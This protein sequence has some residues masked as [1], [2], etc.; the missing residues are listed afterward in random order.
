[1]RHQGPTHSRHGLD[2]YYHL[3]RHHRSSGNRRDPYQHAA[4]LVAIHTALTT[5]ASH[6]WIGIFADSLFSVQAVRHHSTNNSATRSSLHYH[7]H[8]LLLERISDLLETR[9]SMSFCATLQKNR[10]HTKIWVNDIADAATKLAV[11]DYS[12]LPLTQALL[13]DVGEI[14]PRSTLGHVHTNPPSFPVSIY[15][16]QPRHP[17]PTL[18]DNIGGVPTINAAYK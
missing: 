2:I 11:T 17:P 12:N 6:D 10:A 3:H 18:V 15:W 9:L 1:M 8:M 4:E 13:V 7:H 5:F 14:A 16:H